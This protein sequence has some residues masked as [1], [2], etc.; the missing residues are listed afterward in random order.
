MV[1]NSVTEKSTELLQSELTRATNLEDFFAENENAL[2]EKSVAD[3]LNEMLIKYNADVSDVVRQAGL[4]NYAYQIFDGRKKAGREKLIQLAFGFP[5][6]LEETQ[7]LLRCGG[8]SELYVKN[9]REAYLMYALGK[10]LDLQQVNELL[11]ENGE[12]TFE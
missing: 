5:L 1:D 3:Y 7:R 12:K 6:T 11:Y 10:H 9:K 8:H 4:T 2:K